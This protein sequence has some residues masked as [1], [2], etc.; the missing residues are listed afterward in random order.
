MEFE[1]TSAVC[2]SGETSVFMNDVMT[3]EQVAKTPNRE[4]WCR[5]QQ[6]IPSENFLFII[7]FKKPTERV[8]SSAHVLMKIFEKFKMISTPM[9]SWIV[10]RGWINSIFFQKLHGDG[11][12]TVHTVSGSSILLYVFVRSTP[13][14]ATWMHHKSMGAMKTTHSIWGIYFRIMDF[15]NLM[16]SVVR[17]SRIC[18]STGIRRWT[19]DGITVNRI[20][21]DASWVWKLETFAFCSL[22]PWKFLAI[23]EFVLAQRGSWLQLSV[24]LE[25][26]I[27]E[28]KVELECSRRFLLI[29]TWCLAGDYRANEQLGLLSMHTLWLRE[30]NRIAVK[31]NFKFN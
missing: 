30:H 9:G 26:S 25:I 6:E 4:P 16:W 22:F 29:L 7:M 27:N 17:K 15:W 28:E 8:D 31:F 23:D 11:V 2:G 13:S 21:C 5:H 20:P 19:V 18:P 14:P 24:W 10:R 1:R 12:R 3:R